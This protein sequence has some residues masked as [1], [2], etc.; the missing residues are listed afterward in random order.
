VF[1]VLTVTQPSLEDVYLQLI[2]DEEDNGAS[3]VARQRTPEAT[4]AAVSS[5]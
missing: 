3:P 4:P 1:P 2:A 5:S